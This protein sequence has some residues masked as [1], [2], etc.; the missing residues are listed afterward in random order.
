MRVLT[1]LF[2]ISMLI[3]T[4]HM[5]LQVFGGKW[6]MG[7][8]RDQEKFKFVNGASLE[9]WGF[10]D[11]A[12]LSDKDIEVFIT[13]L[14]TEGSSRG[15]NIEYP[16]Y[17]KADVRNLPDIEKQ[18]IA[19]RRSIMEKY[20]KEPQL[21]MLI[22]PEKGPFRNRIKYLGDAVY[23]M[24]TQF[25]MRQNVLGRDR[26]PNVQTIHN[27]CLKINSKIGGINQA[28]DDSVRPEIMKVPVMFMGADVTH[29]SPSDMS[30]KPSIAAVVGSCDRNA[31]KYVSVKCWK[32]RTHTH[33]QTHTHTHDHKTPHMVTWD[34]LNKIS[35]PAI[36]REEKKY[37]SLLYIAVLLSSTPLQN[38]IP[39]YQILGIYIL[40]SRLKI[41]MQLCLL[42]VLMH[43]LSFDGPL[44]TLILKAGKSRIFFFH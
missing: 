26:I 6:N 43:I 36:P 2:R 16:E 31:S 9:I 40:K 8:M 13:A 42:E 15:L 35:F 32:T 28:L 25:V 17:G 3:F 39:F 21:I 7:A 1:P 29:P 41:P 34:F 38:L 11:L 18:F 27:I 22:C 12:R 10:L 20:K 44:V 5:L 24:P 19:L 37:F 23:K 14:Y 4:K 33:T 30:K